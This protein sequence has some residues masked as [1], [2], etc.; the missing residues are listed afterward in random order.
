MKIIFIL[1]AIAAAAW[2]NAKEESKK[3]NAINLK[4]IQDMNFKLQQINQALTAK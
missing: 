2:I 3:L 1:T 4:D